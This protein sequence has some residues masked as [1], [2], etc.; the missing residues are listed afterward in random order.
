[1]RCRRSRPITNK[2]DI[3]RA[4]IRLRVARRHRPCDTIHRHNRRRFHRLRLTH[5][6][7]KYAPDTTRGYRLALSPATTRWAYA[8]AINRDP[9]RRRM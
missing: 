2:R 4:E 8:L 7:R 1:M 9:T 6:R 3:N 5:S